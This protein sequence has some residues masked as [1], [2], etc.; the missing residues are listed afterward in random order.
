MVLRVREIIEALCFLAALVL[1][2]IAG[3]SIVFR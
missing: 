3:H 2:P 1:G